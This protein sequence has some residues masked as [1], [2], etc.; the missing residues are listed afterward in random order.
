MGERPTASIKSATLF[1]NILGD[2]ELIDISGGSADTLIVSPRMEHY[3]FSD[4]ATGKGFL[5]ET[6]E[7]ALKEGKIGRL[8]GMNVFKSNLIGP[9]TPLDASVAANTGDAANTEYI[10]YDHG[11]LGIAADIE[12]LRLVEDDKT[13]VG[14]FAQ[15][16][17]LMGGIVANPALAI[18][19]VA[20]AG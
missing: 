4:W 20:S 10:I 8:F 9:G 14:S 2:R 15:I 5:P 11:T 3:M 13:F 6:N 12:G 18:A 19:K 17:S 1:E 7:A 16:M